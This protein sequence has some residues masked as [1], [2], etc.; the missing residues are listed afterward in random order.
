MSADSHGWNILQ[1][2][3]LLTT[4]EMSQMHKLDQDPDLWPEAAPV[5]GNSYSYVSPG[6]FWTA[7]QAT[8]H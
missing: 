4:R 2:A 5:L 7:P 3:S 6:G 1:A 8:L